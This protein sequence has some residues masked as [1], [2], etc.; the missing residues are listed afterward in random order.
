MPQRKSNTT[1]ASTP[2]DTPLQIRSMPFAEPEGYVAHLVARHTAQAIE[3][4]HAAA[5]AH[6]HPATPIRRWRW[7]GVA[8][9]LLLMLAAGWT[10]VNMSNPSRTD[11]DAQR[12]ASAAQKSPLDAYLESIDDEEASLMEYY[13]IEEVESFASDVTEP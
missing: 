11:H 2:A 6:Q 4:G 3:S 10:M 5:S 1:S 13:E 9:S 8:A 7:A 12:I